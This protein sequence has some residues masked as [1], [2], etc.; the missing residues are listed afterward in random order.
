[1]LYLQ[2]VNLKQLDISWKDTIPVISDAIQLL[3]ADD[4]CQPI[5]PYVKFK[6]ST[7]RI[8][9]MPAYIGGETAV[10]GIKWI[11]SF[12]ENIMNGLPR[13]H[14]V[15]ILNDSK[16]GKPICILNSALISEIRTASLTGYVVTR[17]LENKHHLRNFVIGIV[18]FGPIG[19]QHL[20]MLDYLLGDRIEKIYLYDKKEVCLDLVPE[21]QRKK[22]V[23]CVDW[24]IPFK[25]ADIFITA[26]ISSNGYIYGVPKSGA[27]LLNISLRDF[28]PEIMDH[29]HTII[30]DD[31]DEVCRENTDIEN[32]HKKLGL[33]REQTVP[34]TEFSQQF[35]FKDT[36]S[37]MFNPMGMGVFD[38]ALAGY[39]YQRALKMNVGTHL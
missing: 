35:I 21:N 38:I 20:N 2:E 30:V 28:K 4:Y 18:G 16:T 15:T 26:T 6:N 8:I 24:E 5:K 32:M 39:Y 37:V 36:E 19:R 12:P 7:S 33:K 29:V 13:A 10:A 1:M 31:W 22:I 17:Y 34:I 3:C 11:A 27:L 9:A 25:S 23:I 14:S